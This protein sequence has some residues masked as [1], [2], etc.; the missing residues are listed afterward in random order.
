[1][2]ILSHE[3]GPDGLT[4]RTDGG[5][6]ALTPRT[7]RTVR[8]RFTLAAAFSEKP[9]LTVVR[10]PAGTPAVPFAVAVSRDSITLSTDD[11]TIE[12]ARETAALTYR[13]IEGTVLTREPARG[14]KTLTPIQVLRSEFDGATPHESRENVDG[15]R[16]DVDGIRQVVDRTAFH[17]KLE[18][19]WADGE[20]L[21]GLGS[22]EE[23]MFNLRGQH[24][25]LYQQ[26]LKAVV[27]VLLST[28]GYGVFVD[29]TSL[30][31]FHDDSFGSYLWADVDEELDY[32][33]VVG[34]EFDEIVTELRRLTG[35]ASMLPKWAFGYIQSKERYAT[36]TELLDV[37]REYRARRLPLDCI[38]LDWKSWVGDLWGQKSLDPGRFPDPDRMTEELHALGVR[39]MVSIWPIMRPGGDDWQELADGGH[40]LGNQATY[41]AFSSDARDAYWRQANRGLFSHGI[42]AWWSDCT[43]PFE[44]DWVGAVKPEPEERMR[45]N[46]EEA[47]RYLDPEVINAYS[48]VHSEGIYRGQRATSSSKRVLNLT[49]SAFPG[50]Q[51]YG[52]VTWSG[53]VSAT[54]DTL[55]RQIADG[56]NFCVTGMPYWTTDV[57]A[58]FVTRRPELW[59][60]AGDY[61][62]GVDD[63]GYRELYARWFQYAA[64]LPMLR[65]H[66]TDIAREVW[67]FGE[68]GDA[69]YEAIAAAL[70]LRYR[71]LP[72]LYALAGWTTQHAYTMLRSLPFD[73]R[74][75]P[76]VYDL[77]DQF[78]CGPAFLVCPV[79]APMAYGP[80]SAPLA[81]RPRTRSVYLPAGSDWYD[82]WTDRRL[83]GGQDIQ[84]E[85]PPERIPVFVRAGS[86]VPMGPV[87]QHAN[88]LPHEPVE[89]HVYPGRDA[90]FSFYEDE[91]DGYGYEGG[92]FSSIDV[93][94]DDAA[95]SLTIGERSGGFPGMQVEREFVVA[96]HAGF[97]DVESDGQPRG[98]TDTLRLRYAGQWVAVH[99]DDPLTPAR[100]IIAEPVRR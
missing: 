5:L 77:A 18:F 21:Y 45:I 41:D 99:W 26:N 7:S 89:L 30:M 90:A 35:R 63:L 53:D 97:D 43:E 78:M 98:R 40:L 83:R 95:R 86:I 75:D 50:Q 66:G 69:S 74:D 2:K 28:R 46:T 57:G 42:D 71:L 55:R 85:A 49:R 8:V 79:H 93:S 62:G 1:M 44:A 10:S 88:D 87:R 37:A 72:Y 27:P 76:A 15:V 73:F 22:H 81:H 52:A 19:C 32:Y 23:G 100:G 70:R 91:G 13:T 24:Q 54:W 47:K 11:F 6:L 48:L 92:A 67:R 96:F 31:T 39:L 12:V 34:P 17:T 33:V 65:S 25:Y 29:C 51:R 94:W 56:L 20:A 84:A 3:V 59:F 64:W 58:F 38:V 68:P 82:L 4:I 36:Q 9:S 61:D 80:G 16:I 14:G 60:W